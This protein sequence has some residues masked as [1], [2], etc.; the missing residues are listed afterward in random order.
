MQQLNSFFVQSACV[1]ICHEVFMVFVRHASFC[2][3]ALLGVTR[4]GQMKL[5][6][7]QSI[8]KTS[9]DQPYLA[10]LLTFIFKKSCTSHTHTQREKNLI[11]N[12]GMSG[13]DFRFTRHSPAFRSYPTQK[14]KFSS[15]WLLFHR[16][17]FRAL[18][19]T[20]FNRQ[21]IKDLAG[22]S[23]EVLFFIGNGTTE[24]QHNI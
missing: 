2:K 6:R 11:Y 22:C 12:P 1:T 4:K 21:L 24:S 9:G 19:F 23:S 3:N 10:P 5:A 20:T 14:D 8:C 17:L 16:L 13:T 7:P 18:L 15:L